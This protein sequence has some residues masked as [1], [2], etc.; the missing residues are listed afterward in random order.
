MSAVGDALNA[1]KSIV[2]MDER[3]RRMQD[4]IDRL[5]DDV[6]G[7]VHVAQDLDKRLYAL[8]RIIDFGARQVQQRQIGGPGDGQ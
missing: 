5:A 2:I 4:D 8:E 6:R 1:L 7:L 3:V